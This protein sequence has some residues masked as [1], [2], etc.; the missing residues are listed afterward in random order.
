MPQYIMRV[1]F[2][3]QGLNGVKEVR[4]GKRQIARYSKA[5]R[6]GTQ[7]RLDDIRPPMILLIITK[8]CE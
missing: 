6:S 5:I 8:W 1:K 2:T 7:N 4:T 3:D